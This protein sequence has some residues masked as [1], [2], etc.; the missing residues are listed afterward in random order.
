MIVRQPGTIPA[1]AVSDYVWAFWDF[2]PTAAALARGVVPKGLDGASVVPA[3]AGE[4]QEEH[5][6]LYWEFH[7]RG[8][9]RAVRTGPWKAVS[10]DPRTPLELYYVRSDPGERDNVASAR[11]DVVTRIEAYLQTARTE[12]QD[13]PIRVK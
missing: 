12:S 3:L 7:E 9:T 5:A 2:L 11:P 10:L 13:W 4:S 1:G 8:F 6:F